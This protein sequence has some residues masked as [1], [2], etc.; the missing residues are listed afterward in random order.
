MNAYE[1]LI[2]SDP[3]SVPVRRIIVADSIVQVF[4]WLADSENSSA[5]NT[6]SISVVHLPNAVDM[7]DEAKTEI[8]SVTKTE[9]RARSALLDPAPTAT[10]LDALERVAAKNSESWLDLAER[11]QK[12]NENIRRHEHPGGLDSIESFRNPTIH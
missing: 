2:A 10:E 7:R 1:L 4:R 5:Y 11:V 9:S 6:G 8:K 3:A 12:L